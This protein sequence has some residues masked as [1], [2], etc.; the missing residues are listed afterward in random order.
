M[1]ATLPCTVNVSKYSDLLV[2]ERNIRE[3]LRCQNPVCT[4]LQSAEYK[5]IKFAITRALS[6]PM[7]NHEDDTTTK[8]ENVEEER[9]IH[10]P[11]SQLVMY[12]SN[13][14]M[15]VLIQGK[16]AAVYISPDDDAAD[17][18]NN[19]MDDNN[20]N[21][22][23][24]TTLGSKRK[25]AAVSTKKMQLA[26]KKSGSRYSNDGN[27]ETTTTTTTTAIDIETK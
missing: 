11:H 23:Q 4:F 27:D 12:V 15:T 1:S 10:I 22:K 14:F 19:N 26:E 24:N 7:H 13:D 8:P 21:N 18:N 17:N 3:L 16:A 20:N 6:S 9:V 2:L 5:R 25:R